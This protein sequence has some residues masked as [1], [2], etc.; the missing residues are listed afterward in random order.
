[1]RKRDKATGG[2][3]C[4]SFR[5]FLTFQSTPLV[6]GWTRIQSLANG[7]WKEEGAST[8]DQK[9]R[10]APAPSTLFLLAPLKNK[11]PH[12]RG[13]LGEIPRIFSGP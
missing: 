6:M 13:S 1:M 10:Q 11:P 12:F 9:Y 7:L 4:N 5:D 2:K 3:T 8:M